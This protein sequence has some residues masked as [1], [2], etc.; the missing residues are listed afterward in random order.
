MSSATLTGAMSCLA[1]ET[2]DG[3]FQWRVHGTSG[4]VKGAQLGPVSGRVSV[5][6]T[7]TATVRPGTLYDFQICGRGTGTAPY[8]QYACVGPNGPASY[9]TFTS[10]QSE[11]QQAITAQQFA[12]SIGVNYHYGSSTNPASTAQAVTDM[13]WLGVTHVRMNVIH[14]SNSGLNSLV[15][16]RWTEVTNGGFKID[17]QIPPGCSDYYTG[18]NPQG[19]QDCIKQ[20]ET[21]DP[22]LTGVEAFEAPNE[23][24][25]SGDP[26]W[27]TDLVPWIGA[28]GSNAPINPSTGKRYPVYGPAVA[29]SWC[30]PTSA[31]VLAGTTGYSGSVFDVQNFHDYTG[32]RSPQPSI[33]T[34]NVNFYSP[35]VPR[36]Y[37]IIASEAGF[38]D[39]C[40]SGCGYPPI[41][42]A[43]A[44]V[45]T[46]RTYLEHLAD[47][48]ARTYLY[49]L[50][51]ESVCPPSDG[52]GDA[53]FGL[54]DSTDTAK[55]SA[56]A[57]HN[58][59]TLIGSG[60]PART[61]PLR[62]GVEAGD[63]TSDL[64]YLDIQLSDGSHDLVLWR[65]CMPG[66]DQG[67]C[68]S[69]VWNRDTQQDLTVTPITEHI[70]FTQVGGGWQQAD[71]IHSASFS[72]VSGSNPAVVQVGADPVVI[73][74]LTS[75]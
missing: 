73:H 58:L 30:S 13:R 5:P 36:G 32:S 10:L 49:E 29:C 65:T 74:V 28:L 51:D 27:N 6:I 11:S 12:D 31:Q 9:S 15:W 19:V 37:P 41:D 66:Q 54:F 72:A 43:G 4:W 20:L 70:D 18:W 44:A 52:C 75:S 23:P 50:Y 42:R 53:H 16:S 3:Y 55:P 46:L 2:C 1:G 7:Y 35:L 25:L 61:T 69:S 33:V 59:T 22:G 63:P 62:W 47:G 68:P 21:Q 24:D 64:R 56:T 34:Y 26:T 17:V 71:P 48:L 67:T 40:T 57:L 14:S 39:Q 8:P 45:Y 38:M 60:A